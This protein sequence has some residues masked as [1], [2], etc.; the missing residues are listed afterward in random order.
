VAARRFGNARVLAVDLSLASLCYA[1][2]MSRAFGA[3]SIEYAQADILELPSLGRTFHVIEASGVLH[4][5]A[6]PMA[7]WRTL[8]SLLRPGGFMRI[9]LYSKS[10]RAQIQAARDLLAQSDA[11]PTANE[12]R[13]WRRKLLSPSTKAVANFTDFFSISE[14][15]DLLFHVQ[16][17]QL[18]IPEIEAFL[19]DHNLRFIGFELHPPVIAS[20][21]FRFPED[22]AMASLGSWHVFEKE[23]PLTFAGMYQFWVQHQ[24]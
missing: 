9:G 14:C 1:K 17:H 20:Y 8:L 10:G 3:P 5:F 21:R 24:Q 23:N 19:R 6:E 22:R 11:R 2:R 13:R 18:S 15:R 4:H 12:I 16:E 7:G